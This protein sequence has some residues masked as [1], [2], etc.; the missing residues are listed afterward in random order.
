M[1]NADQL[2]KFVQKQLGDRQ[3]IVAIQR[4]PYLHE[5]DG[6]NIKT[7][8]TAGG[9]HILM[10]GIL[11]KVGGTMVALGQGG[12][13]AQV[14]DKKGRIK[15]PPN[16]EKYTL[17]RI[18]LDDKEMDGF[19]YGFANQTLWPLC[20]AVFVQ[21]VFNESWWRA[22][23]EVNRKFAN[24]VLEEI[25]GDKAFVWVND[26][27]LALV[28]QMIKEKKPGVTV[29]LFWH[30]PWPTHE[31]FRITPWRKLII[32]GML[33]ADFIGFHRDYHVDNF[34]RTCRRELGVIIDT[35]PRS[36]LYNKH[37]TKVANVPAGSDYHEIIDKLDKNKSDTRKSMEKEFGFSAQYLAI[38]VDRIDYTKGLLERIQIIDRFLE[39]YP[40]YQGKFVYLS[41]G[42]PSRIKIP[43]YQ[44]FN[45]ELKNLINRVNAK[46][47]KKGWE[48][49]K[50]VSNVLPREKIFSYYRMADVCMVTSL[51]DGMNL[52]AKEYV[53]CTPPHKG[54]LVISKFTGAAKDL[55]QAIQVN[56]YDIE[57]SA[58]LLNTAFTMPA[59]EKKKRNIAMQEVLKENNI[60]KW[61]VDF[62]RQGSS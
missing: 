39:K 45:E 24:A 1:T 62:I 26:Y 30:I 9:A 44:K 28:P 25:K 52:V 42:A 34:I 41:I 19:Y 11:R 58:K 46:Y 49:I 22:Y 55:S 29:G 4:E 16:Q 36:I 47:A 2:V 48:P 14:V 6:K 10:D 13:D 12:A 50:F 7:K 5:F 27:H 18:F 23:I 33:G 56:P 3:F 32:S 57:D 15:V 21:P 35:E 61:G 38:G 54:M 40:K 60:Y 8:K 37:E 31:I 51:D 53:I 59:A 43:A 17:K 20:H